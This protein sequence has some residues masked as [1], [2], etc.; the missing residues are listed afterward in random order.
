[1]KD[2]RRV[3][4]SL[5]V[6]PYIRKISVDMPIYVDSRPTSWVRIVSEPEWALVKQLDTM[7]DAL[8]DFQPS[9]DDADMWIA[10]CLGFLATT[11][12]VRK[13]YVM[14]R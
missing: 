1:M 4:D 14:F 12:C 7:L 5:K 9:E 6:F 3:S 8:L 2:K 10:R 11:E 13:S